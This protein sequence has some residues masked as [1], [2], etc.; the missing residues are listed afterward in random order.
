MWH[1]YYYIKLECSVLLICKQCIL[2][3]HHVSLSTAN[4]L[5]YVALIA[6]Y[7]YV[8]MS[9]LKKNVLFEHSP[10]I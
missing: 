4:T 7:R 5:V 6:K 10:A 3:Y 1:M 2:G 9:I 8:D